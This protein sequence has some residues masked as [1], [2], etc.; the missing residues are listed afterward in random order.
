MA[1]KKKE[2]RYQ[3]KKHSFYHSSFDN[4]GECNADLPVAQCYIHH[5]T[6]SYQTSLFLCQVNAKMY[7]FKDKL[8]YLQGKFQFQHPDFNK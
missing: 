1:N 3:V 2:Y 5:L 6:V 4:R 7:I 8:K